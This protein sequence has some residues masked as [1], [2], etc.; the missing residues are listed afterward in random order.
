MTAIEQ[1]ERLIEKLPSEEFQ[2]LAAWVERRRQPHRPEHPLPDDGTDL[3]AAN[4]EFRRSGH[5]S[6]IL[7]DHSAFLNSYDP[8]DEGLYDDAAAR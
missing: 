6:L 2:K 5:A 7:R 3:G 1:I 8:D 4:P